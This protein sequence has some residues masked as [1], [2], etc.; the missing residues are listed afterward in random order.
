M[1]LYHPYAQLVANEI[2][3]RRRRAAEARRGA[4]TRSSRVA[5]VR[6][7]LGAGLVALGLR[8]QGVRPVAPAIV[9]S[10]TE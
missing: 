5:T 1:F 2:E 7:R 3:R 4:I 8:L 10:A 6:R 9:G